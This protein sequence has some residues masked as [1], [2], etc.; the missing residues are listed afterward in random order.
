MD[1]INESMSQGSLYGRKDCRTD[2]MFRPYP[3]VMKYERQFLSVECNEFN[4]SRAAVTT[5]SRSP[6]T[7]LPDVSFGFDSRTVP[8]HGAIP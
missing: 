2:R 6:L 1:G 3:R 5:E 8:V 7:M 4:V